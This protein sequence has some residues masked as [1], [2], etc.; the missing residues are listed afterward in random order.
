LRAGN[1]RDRATLYRYDL[2]YPTLP[3]GTTTNPHNFMPN[4]TVP[5]TFAQR[6]LAQTQIAVFFATNGQR[7]IDPDGDGAIF[8]TPAGTLPEDTGFNP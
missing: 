8:E 2:L 3:K 7:T 6:D 1:L 4:L 5:P